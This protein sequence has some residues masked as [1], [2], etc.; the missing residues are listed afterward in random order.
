MEQLA[1]VACAALW[2]WNAGGGRDSG[3]LWVPEHWLIIPSR[4]LGCGG[5]INSTWSRRWIKTKEL[6]VRARLISIRRRGWSRWS[7][8]V[9]LMMIR[10]IARTC[11]AK[12]NWKPRYASQVCI[13][14]K[15]TWMHLLRPH[16]HSHQ[17]SLSTITERFYVI[18]IARV[19]LVEW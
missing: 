2:Q 7:D 3:T 10:R 5:T 1:W 13:P 18:F 4:P 17:E 9:T 14:S 11:L 15:T 8:I 12:S 19:Q 6:L 16:H